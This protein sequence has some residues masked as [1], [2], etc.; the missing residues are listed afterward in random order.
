MGSLQSGTA[1]ILP[2]R[3]STWN[4]RGRYSAGADRQGL[5][6]R[7]PQSLLLNSAGS[8]GL[9]N[10]EIEAKHR[11][12]VLRGGEGD[13][14]NRQVLQLGELLRD[15]SDVGR[16]VLPSAVRNGSQVGTVRFNQQPI[17]GGEANCL[18]Q[19]LGLFVGQDAGDRQLHVEVQV[20]T[21]VIHVAGKAV[22]NA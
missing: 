19:S 17:E 10:A 9:L 2:S 5:D 21:R 8:R 4:A 6:V 16:L 3:C 13:L 20:S 14:L 11:R 12:A 22:D 1:R 15:L 18:L 7:F